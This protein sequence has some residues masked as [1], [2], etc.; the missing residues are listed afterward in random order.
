MSYIVSLFK[1]LSINYITCIPI[2]IDDNKEPNGYG[3]VIDDIVLSAYH[4]VRNSNKIIINDKKYK[5]ELY[6]DEYDIVILNKTNNIINYDYFLNK[7]NTYIIYKIKNFESIVNKTFNIL[8]KKIILDDLQCNHVVTNIFPPVPVYIF[9]SIIENFDYSGYSGSMIRFKNNVLCMLISEN[10]ETKKITGLPLEIIY[11]ILKGYINNNMKFYY[12]PII[13]TD[14]ILQNNFRTLVKNDQIKTI[15]NQE[16]ENNMIYD[17]DLNNKILLD[18]YILL[19]GIQKVYIEYYRNYK[20]KKKEHK[21]NISLKVFNYK[22]ISINF[23]DTD[24]DI[25]ISNLLFSELS[26]ERIINMYNKNIKIPNNIYDNIFTSKKI[27]LKN[28]I[29]SDY[30]L[31]RYLLNNNIDISNEIYIL[32]KIS[33][34]KIRN[35]KDIEKFTKY[36]NITIEL[37]NTNMDN[38]KIK[39]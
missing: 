16:I 36:K 17:I 31:N 12:L 30:K 20:K 15:N 32:D 21:N 35:I 39:I 22:N 27:F 18:T 11:K 29:D 4:V 6:I 25:D 34:K 2:Y 3:M 13:L 24:I 33:G 8:D 5:I 7:L 10:I 19:N 23:R 38:I 37:I 9:S 14:N 1:Y 26:E 28:I